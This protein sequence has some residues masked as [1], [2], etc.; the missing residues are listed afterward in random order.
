[1][2]VAYDSVC[3]VKTL[4]SDQQTNHMFMNKP[5]FSRTLTSRQPQITHTC[6]GGAKDT[7]KR[8]G[9]TKCRQSD[10]GGED[11]KTPEQDLKLFACQTGPDVVNEGVNLTEAEDTQRLRKQTQNAPI[12]YRSVLFIL[13][14][15][16]Q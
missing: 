15:T 6:I 16:K 5:S 7:A 13:S 1:M 8:R 14:F 10:N 4:L 9:D 2:T 11:D 3:R 12:T